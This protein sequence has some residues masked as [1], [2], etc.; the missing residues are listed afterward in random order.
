[1]FI[2]FGGDADEVVF[3][4]VVDMRFGERRFGFFVMG[5][6]DEGFLLRIDDIVFGG[7]MF[8]KKEK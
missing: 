7:Y 6:L 5:G 3:E 2:W 8:C 4:V 1:M